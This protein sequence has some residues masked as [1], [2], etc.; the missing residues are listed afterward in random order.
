MKIPSF[1]TARLEKARAKSSKSNVQKKSPPAPPSIADIGKMISGGVEGA[2]SL[3]GHEGHLYDPSITPEENNSNIQ[4]YYK[5]LTAKGEIGEAVRLAQKAAEI[6]KSHGALAARAGNEEISNRYNTG[7]QF[8]N[9]LALMQQEQFAKMKQQFALEMQQ[10]PEKP[11]TP[12]DLHSLKEH[13]QDVIDAH[14]KN[15]NF[16]G[17]QTAAHDAAEA[18][19]S[20]LETL[21]PSGSRDEINKIAEQHANH[22]LDYAKKQ[23]D[24]QSANLEERWRQNTFNPEHPLYNQRMA[25]E[26]LAPSGKKK[27]QEP[28]HP[29]S[30]ALDFPNTESNTPAPT[31]T[32]IS[33]RKVDDSV[34]EYYTKLLAPDSTEL[35]STEEIQNAIEDLKLNTPE[36]ENIEKRRQVNLLMDDDD[37]IEKHRQQT[38]EERSAQGL[39]PLN[40]HEHLSDFKALKYILTN[41]LAPEK[42]E[43]SKEKVS[44]SPFSVETLREEFPIPEDIT[45]QMLTDRIESRHLH[46]GAI[47]AD[48]VHKNN[49]IN[50][51]KMN[52][53]RVKRGLQPIP[54]TQKPI[55]VLQ[56]AVDAIMP[57]SRAG[58]KDKKDEDVTRNLPDFMIPGKRMN[59]PLLQQQYMQYKQSTGQLYMPTEG[60]DPEAGSRAYFSPENNPATAASQA[61]SRQ[62][63]NWNLTQTSG[64][65]YT[66]SAKDDGGPLI[67][68]LPALPPQ[69]IVP[70]ATEGPAFNPEWGGSTV[71]R[72]VK[73]KKRPND[74]V[75][76]SAFGEAE[77]GQERS[78]VTDEPRTIRVLEGRP[79]EFISRR[80]EDWLRSRRG[81]PQKPPSP[82]FQETVPLDPSATKR[83]IMSNIPDR[84][85]D[86][87]ANEI[88][89]RTKASK[90][91][92]EKS[93]EK[94]AQMAKNPSF[95]EKRRE[96]ATAQPPKEEDTVGNYSEHMEEQKTIN[97][98]PYKQQGFGSVTKLKN[99]VA[100]LKKK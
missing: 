55:N 54:F 65:G 9:K 99:M 98:K 71:P 58:A 13:M 89:K 70:S 1:N 35:L 22:F 63:R 4:R 39:A 59:D 95:L 32:E 26:A 37:W 27:Q 75:P 45:T 64:G 28:E 67:R 30:H 33:P 87:V 85:T 84:Y 100:K 3:T 43:Q 23:P 60:E 73:R 82:S 62:R 46:M 8:W 17:A 10:N 34:R 80:Q 42:D 97:D 76:L 69:Q 44:K 20:E 68:P 16:K 14:V 53:S 51:Q 74:S 5:E 86:N 57:N 66:V 83:E 12:K 52:T 81:V 2:F 50:H 78:N 93:M 21:N 48:A 47:I 19:I 6:F 49:F 90:K 77:G 15:G 31:E 72:P 7:S 88:K 29:R 24:L 11:K 94:S 40:R 25:Y 38:N 61:E 79:P 36:F 92:T 18:F 41:P 91:S 96:G 56:A